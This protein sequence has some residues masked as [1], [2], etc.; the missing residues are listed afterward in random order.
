MVVLFNFYAFWCREVINFNRIHFIFVKLIIQREIVA[1]DALDIITVI[2]SLKAL[3]FQHLFLWLQI[4]S[5]LH[6]ELS[7][8]N[9][10]IKCI[11]HLFIYLNRLLSSYQII[12]LKFL[13]I[14]VITLAETSPFCFLNT[15]AVLYWCEDLHFIFV[16]KIKVIFGD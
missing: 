13:F 11:A 2:S 1:L 10:L 8:L 3:V 14:L 12:S 6:H 16:Q 5:K 4:F 7:S 15:W 9:Q